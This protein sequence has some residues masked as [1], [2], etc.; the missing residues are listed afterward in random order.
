MKWLKLALLNWVMCDLWKSCTDDSY[1]KVDQTKGEIYLMDSEDGKDGKKL[2]ENEVRELIIEANTIL[3][4]PIFLK[5]N[6]SIKNTARGMIFV[7]SKTIDD[8]IAG[9]MLLWGID[10]MEKKYQ[11]I[12]NL[13]IAEKKK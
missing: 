9:K 13:K 6:S 1:L 12:A 5:V 7:K 3:K 10:V 4:L 8:I 2:P 11:N